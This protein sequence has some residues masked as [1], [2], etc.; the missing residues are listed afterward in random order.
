MFNIRNNRNISLLINKYGLIVCLF[1]STFRLTFS[2]TEYST[3]NNYRGDWQTPASWEPIWDSPQTNNINS[4][5]TIN[6]YISCRASITI[7]GNGNALTINDTLLICGDLTID[8]TSSL[9]LNTNAIV[10]ISGNLITNNK[11][12]ITLDTNACI[13]VIGDYIKQ[14]SIKDGSFISY[15]Q[16][17]NVFIGGNVP[18]G[19]V[20]TL[21]PVFNCPGGSPYDSSQCGYGNMQDLMNC[22]IY[23]FFHAV[24]SPSSIITASGPLTFCAGDSVI[25]TSS[26]GGDY[27]WSTGETSASIVVNTSGIYTVIVADAGICPVIDRPSVVVHVNSLP[28]AV[29]AVTDNT[30]IANDD[31]IICQGTTATLTASGGAYY[32]WSTGD[33]IAEITTD[34]AGL[35]TVTVTDTNGC[36]N[37]VNDTI[38]HI[39]L[40][41]VNAGNGGDACGNTYALNATSSIGT[42]TWTVTSGSGDVTFIPDEN[43]PLATIRIVNYGN[44]QLVWTAIN[45]NCPASA[46]VSVTFHEIP[47]ANAG[48]GGDTCGNTY[49]LNASS[50][51]G[52][53]TWTVTSGSGD[54]TF[55][56]DENDPSATMRIS[57]FGNYQLV[58]TAVSENCPASDEVS[59]TFHEIPVAN[60]GTD[61]VLNSSVATTMDADVSSSENGEWSLISGSGII[62]NITSPITPITDL[63]QGENIFLWTVSSTYCSASDSVIIT[64]NITNLLVPQVITPN[65]DGKNDFLII[66]GIENFSPA[67]LVILNRWGSEVYSNPDYRN[68]WRGENDKGTGLSEDTYY[69]ILNANGEVLNGFVVIKR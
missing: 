37:T 25:L 3:R 11:G 57:N 5:I 22:P 27:F 7:N 24:N 19:L 8:N 28:E 13:I 9:V 1:L 32:S 51:I 30:G 65:N 48:T 53:G 41:I 66:D 35:Y 67:K 21:F 46:D 44:Y 61:Q 62:E 29:I 16:P 20:P 55:I 23:P 34:I 45:E 39:A 49:T 36:E 33:I 17:S 26:E 15:N 18:E 68:D 4:N 64:V 12:S 54:V 14:G 2:Q 69:Y 43:D 56:P 6:G 60:A 31:G 40:P 59:I 10:I 50:S 52:T 42:G 47:V 58:W 63:L 38:F